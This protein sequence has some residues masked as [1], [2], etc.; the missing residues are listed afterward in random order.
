M[1]HH[2]GMLANY[3]AGI[4]KADTSQAYNTK[5]VYWFKLTH[6]NPVQ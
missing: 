4:K 3:Q 5:Q 6:N 1:G 2:P